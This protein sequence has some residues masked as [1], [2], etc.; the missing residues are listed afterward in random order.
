MEQQREG[1]DGGLTA[2]AGFLYQTV[3]TLGLT[4]GVLAYPSDEGTTDLETLLGIA[5]AGEVRKEHFDQCLRLCS[6]CSS[7]LL[8]L[9]LCLHRPLRLTQEPG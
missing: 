9:S 7:C 8:L 5:A 6:P 1:S 2:L 4:V 3:G